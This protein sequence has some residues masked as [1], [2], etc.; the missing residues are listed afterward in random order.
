[1]FVKSHRSL[2]Q[3]LVRL[4]SHAMFSNLWYYPFSVVMVFFV[5]VFFYVF[6]KYIHNSRVSNF[7]SGQESATAIPLGLFS[8]TSLLTIMCATGYNK[9]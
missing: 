7:K 5:R 8:E 1:M 2:K 9:P 6:A 4:V 3:K